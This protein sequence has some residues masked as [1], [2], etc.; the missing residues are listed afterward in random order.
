MLFIGF[1]P[2][3]LR[4]SGVDHDR[5]IFNRPYLVCD[6]GSQGVLANAVPANNANGDV[7]IPQTNITFTNQNVPSGGSSTPLPTTSPGSIHVYEIKY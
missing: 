7:Y 5:N 1:R 4:S 3:R 6:T 2:P